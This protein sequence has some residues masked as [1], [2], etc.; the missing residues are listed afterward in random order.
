M[1]GFVGCGRMGG[2]ML[3]AHDEDHTR[4]VAL[5]LADARVE[6]PGDASRFPHRGAR[7]G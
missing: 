6:L 2:P 7:F 1:I 4:L 3:R 5:L